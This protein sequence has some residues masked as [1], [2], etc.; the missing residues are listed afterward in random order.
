MTLILKRSSHVARR[1][2]F[3][4][5]GSRRLTQW[6]GP[7]IQAYV[8]VA[9]GGATLIAQLA[10]EEQST[11]VRNR[12]MVSIRP[13]SYAADIDINGAYGIGIASAEAVAA[14]VASVPEPFTDGDWGGWMVWRSFA[15]HYEFASAISTFESSWQTEVDSKA[16][17]KVS[18]NEVAV[19]V[20]ES[21]SGAFFIAEGIRTLIK[22]S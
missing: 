21:Q 4:H 14:G 19:F 8:A 5:S 10:F 1:R 18:P 9:S 6:A 20:A 22:L 11:I 17:R 7:A 16:M 15:F 3:G 12:G 2:S 13:Q